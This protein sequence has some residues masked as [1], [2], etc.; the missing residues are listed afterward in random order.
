MGRM[1]CAPLLFAVAATVLLF[2]VSAD[3]VSAGICDDVRV[4]IQNEDGTYDMAMVGGV[5]TV[6]SAVTGAAD[7]LGRDIKLNITGTNVQSV[8]GLGNDTDHQWRLFQWLP[9]G[10]AGWGVQTFSPK[11]DE[12]MATGTTYCV[13]RSTFTSR[14]GTIV[15]SPPTFEPEADGYV[16]VRFAN[17]FSPDDENVNAVFTPEIRERGFWLKGRG[18]DMGKVLFD[19]VDSNWPG[20]IELM[21]ADLGG[22]NLSSWVSSMFG[23]GDVKIDENV[24]AYWSQWTWVDHKW[25]YNENTLGYYDPAVH[26]YLEVIYLISTPDPYGGG[27]IIDKGGEEPNPDTDE[28]TCLK[29]N[30]VAEFRLGDGSAWA[31]QDLK[32]GERIDMTQIADPALPSH[33]FVGWGDTASPLYADAVFTASFAPVTETMVRV[34]Y[35]NSDGNFIVNEY[36]EPGSAA[37]YGGIPTKD[38]TRQYDYVFEEWSADLSSVPADTVVTPVFRDELREYDVRFHGHDR[39]LLAA[40]PTK[41]GTPAEMPPDPE[42][43]STVSYR[44]VFRGWSLTP[45][46]MVAVDLDCVTGDVSVFAFFEPAAK[47]YTLTFKE[48]GVTIAEYAA[49]YGTPIGRTYPLDLFKGEHI[50]KMYR[51]EG[52]TRE[53]DTTHVIIGDTVVHVGRVLGSYDSA[54]DASGNVVGDTVTVSYDGALAG[55]LDASS[56]GVVICDISQFPNGTAASIDRESLGNVHRA[57]SPG[58]PVT[59]KVPRGSVTMVATD[60]LLV[61]GDGERLTFSVGNG[62]NNV[63]ISTA[64]KKINHSAFYRLNLRSDNVSVMDLSALGAVAEVSLLLELD[65]GVRSNVWNITATGATTHVESTHSNSYVHF[66]TDLMQFFAVGTTDPV[67]VRSGVVVPYGKV[68]CALDGSGMDGH[69][70]LVGMTLDNLGGTAFVPSSVGGCTLRAVG[71]GALNG[72]TNAPAVVVPG[73]VASFSWAGWACGASDVYFTGDRPVFEGT[74]PPSVTVHY[75]PSRSGWDPSIGVPDLDV[76]PYE[77]SYKKDTFG[78]TYY[79]VGDAVVLHRYVHGPYVTVPES[80]AVDGTDYPVVYVGDGA[81]MHSADPGVAAAYG[82]EYSRYALE[83]VELAPSVKGI[84]TRAFLGSTVKTVVN[85]DSLTHVWDEAFLGCGSLSNVRLP[86]GLL[87]IGRQAFEGCAGGGFN[88]VTV[89]DSV[90]AVGEAAFRGCAGLTNVT[91]GKGME[92]VPRNCFEGCPKLTELTI[93]DGVDAIEDEAFRDCVGLLFVDL[94]EVS[95]VGDRAFYSGSGASAM[96]FIVI[97]A[98][99]NGLGEDAFGNNTSLG[100][101]EAHCDYFDGFER[102][103]GNVDLGKVTFYV[104]NEAIGSWSKYDAVPLVEPEIEKDD[105][106]LRSVEIGL[107]LFFAVLAVFSYYWKSR[108]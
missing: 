6:R 22:E 2:A 85:A 36:L 71:P 80:I 63:K 4:Y 83:T 97:G 95:R 21:T 96:E 67:T 79:L 60:F 74:P 77:G 64:L 18:S 29:N 78:F 27:Y 26:R 15:Y 20:Q 84:H 49:K 103:F 61:L 102:A 94:N 66:R 52:L 100:E 56:G 35:L 41:Y 98:T 23:L 62:P 75:D 48:S 12:R 7:E 81:F 108:V 93:P 5:Q 106:L 72:L 13:N 31:S 53:Y 104:A 59:I 47:E 24:W 55:R 82:L 28:I 9:P 10:T 30:L 39:A 76:R 8:D 87:F 40:A 42:R 70:T 90:S 99:L 38:S 92:S 86:D 107:V 25:A 17:G 89:P 73:T 65:E 44:F 43:Q 1:R 58:T 3:D 11:S 88:R 37:T 51:D 68:E 33:G 69:A 14:D 46:N 16:F 45:N 50:A 101:I 32:F 34:K 91:L 105:T 57:V 19:A 54:R